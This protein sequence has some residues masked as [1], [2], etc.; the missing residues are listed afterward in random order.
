MKA[1][2]L[3]G[4]AGF[5]LAVAVA[6]PHL[7]AT[8]AEADDP[9]SIV[10]NIYLQYDEGGELRDVPKEYFTPGLLK[11]W[12]DV[13]AGGE[14]DVED[15][16][17]FPVFN[18]EG[19]DESIAIDDVRLQLAAERYVIASYIV[20]VEEGNVIAVTRKYFQYNFV[21][22]PDGWK[23]DNIDWGREK[24]TLREYLIEIEGLR[25]LRQR[26]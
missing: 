16:L 9:L 11:L 17:G 14:G 26:L 20:L 8:A 7:G 19:E 24:N 6:P 1:V 4:A 2:N 12:R 5:W 21:I 25:A 10:R 15:A 23:I 3:F 22:T 13:E 18:N